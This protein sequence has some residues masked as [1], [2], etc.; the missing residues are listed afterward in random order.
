M[1]QQP[2]ENISSKKLRNV[3]VLRFG[4]FQTQKF[5]RHPDLKMAKVTFTAWKIKAQLLQVRS[6]FYP[7]S[8]YDGPDMRSHA[9]ATVDAPPRK[10]GLC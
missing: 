3:L 9:C 5:F 4:I 6:E 8:M 2:P 7:P 10:T 1:D